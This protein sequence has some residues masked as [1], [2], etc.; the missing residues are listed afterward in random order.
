MVTGRPDSGGG[1]AVI[2]AV[3]EVERC[4]VVGDGLAETLSGLGT[5]LKSFFFELDLFALCLN[6][7][8]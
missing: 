6:A 1:V 7:E 8:T 2:L 5:A 3:V 4:K